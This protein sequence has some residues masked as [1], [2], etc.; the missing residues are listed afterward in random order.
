M[1]ILSTIVVLVLLIGGVLYFVKTSKDSVSTSENTPPP[2]IA[3]DQPSQETRTFNGKL[4]T[5]VAEGGSWECTSSVTSQGVTTKGTS[6]I[7]GTMVRSDFV[8]SVPQYGDIDSHMIMRDET[9][10]TWSNLMP[11]GMKFPLEDGKMKG[12]RSSTE[13]TP[14]FDGEYDYS[15]KAWPTDESKFALPEGVMF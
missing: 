13:V 11:R 12:E 7:G 4:E 6:Y 10:Y 2:G 9:V 5:L 3:S 14:Q 15:C 1:K 8:S